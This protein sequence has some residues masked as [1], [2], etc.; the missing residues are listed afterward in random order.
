MLQAGALAVQLATVSSFPSL[1]VPA[2][3]WV[4]LGAPSVVNAAN[5]DRGLCHPKSNNGLC[6]P[7]W[8]AKP[9]TRL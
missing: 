3:V 7:G 8:S 6:N 9:P 1:T 5:T 4:S 2:K